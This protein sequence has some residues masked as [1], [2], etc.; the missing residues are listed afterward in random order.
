[1]DGEKQNANPTVYAVNDQSHSSKNK[2]GSLP[3]ELGDFFTHIDGRSMKETKT[4]DEFDALEVF[5]M[6]CT[7]T[8]PNTR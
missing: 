8:I 1:M 6:I 3:I 7:S 4:S 2:V 5:E